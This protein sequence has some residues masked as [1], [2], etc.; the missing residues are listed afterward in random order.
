MDAPSAQ[1]LDDWTR[2]DQAAANELFRRYVGRLTALARG[3]ISRR[4]GRR[5]D[6]EDVAHSAFRSFFVRARTGRVTVAENGDLW[7]LLV[8]I[9]V[10][11]LH[12]QVQHNRA[13]KRSFDREQSLATIGDEALTAR[14]TGASPPTVEEAAALAEEFE[15]FLAELSPLERKVIELRMQDHSQSEIAAR[16]GRTERTVRRILTR[17]QQRLE[18]RLLAPDFAEVEDAQSRAA[19]SDKVDGLPVTPVDCIA[20]ENVGQKAPRNPVLPEVLPFG[21]WLSD[22]DFQL[23]RFLGSGGTGKVYQAWW[24]SANEW[25]AVKVLKKRSQADPEAVERFLHEAVAVQ[26]LRHPGIV[27]LRGIGRLKSG[28]YFL[29]LDLVA[30]DDLSTIASAR[31]IAIAEALGWVAGAARA[32]NHAHQQGVIH[33]DLKP[34][35]LLLDA[36]G[37]VHVTDFGLA[38]VLWRSLQ[39]PAAAGTLGFMAPE[40]I[41][42]AWGPIG[43]HTDVFGLGAVLFALLTGKPPFVGRTSQETIEQLLNAPL[44]SVQLN[45]PD[46]G[47]GVDAICRR[48]L[49]P[50][51]GKRYGSA[52]ELA[53]ALHEL[54]PDDD[55]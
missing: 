48:C 16:V 53:S 45:R 18:Q 28:G 43:P 38:R 20:P 30:G 10:N 5:I 50:Q 35:N 27:P 55:R 36:A 22:S 49:S 9:A 14:F 11:K 3:R 21:D 37:A 26:A 31:R 24:R 52:T 7:R 33:C 8:S 12:R 13:G 15:L 54:I 1:L 47:S 40:Q 23:A 19:G 6:A 25:V 39:R 4:L 42:P 32:V 2:G 51:I 46:A 44:P 17:L 41:D 34:G 29:V